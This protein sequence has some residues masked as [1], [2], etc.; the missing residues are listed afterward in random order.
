MVLWILSAIINS[1][2]VIMSIE[3]NSFDWLSYC[4]LGF[5]AL[6]FFYIGEKA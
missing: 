3:L 5:V 4:N 6:S 2:A 1:A